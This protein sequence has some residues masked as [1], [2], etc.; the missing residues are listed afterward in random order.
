MSS[1]VRPEEARGVGTRVQAMMDGNQRDCSSHGCF[2]VPLSRTCHGHGLRDGDRRADAHDGRVAAHGGKAAEDAQD[3]QA[4][5]HCLCTSHQDGGRGAVR[6]LG[7]RRLGKRSMRIVVRSMG[8][9]CR[10][11][12]RRRSR[13]EEGLFIRI[14]TATCLRGGPGGGGPVLLE[15]RRQLGEALQRSLDANAVI[16][17]ARSRSLLTQGP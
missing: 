16:L 10:W 9:K 17:R 14:I 1:R 15:D 5:A 12:E 2:A 6:D 3:R 13:E 11:A 7:K 4:P 8:R